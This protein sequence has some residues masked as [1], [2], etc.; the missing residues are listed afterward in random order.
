MTTATA[1]TILPDGAR[2]PSASPYPLL[3][4]NP[5]PGD[6]F[7]PATDALGELSD[8]LIPV[9]DKVFGGERLSM[10][11]GRLLFATK[12]LTGV[13]A[14]ANWLTE[15]RNG[16]RTTFTFNRHLN[17][18]NVCAY[19]CMFCAFR[20]SGDEDDA[21]TMDMDFVT[22]RIRNEFTDGM[23]EV[24]VVG[25]IHP[26][27]PYSYYL[28][29]LRTIKKTR[30]H[31]HIKGF[32]MIELNEIAKQAG[33]PLDVVVRELKEAGLDSCPGGGAEVLSPRVHKKLYNGKL[34]PNEWLDAVRV[35]HA[36]GLKSNATMLFGHIESLEER[37]EHLDQIRRLQDETQ[38]FMQFIPLVFHPDNTPL[39]RL[40][41][42][43][44]VDALR[45]IAISRLML[46]NIPHIKAYWIMVGLRIAQIALHYGADDI[47]GTVVEEH[48]THDAG[49]TTPQ[50]LTTGRLTAL[51]SETGR[52][53]V[54]RDTL[55][56]DMLAV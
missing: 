33:K 27:L 11:D 52:Q 6:E 14:L 49:A 34:P 24:H 26:E 45:T 36:A 23:K 41:K 50:G 10:D 9:R 47:D 3:P 4:S 53:P 44:G 13:G 20:R 18:T 56:E 2:V 22:N 12:D 51:I 37:L 30:P 35:V 28:D 8:E 7:E 1:N 38:G 19:K 29:L 32:T 46:D 15:T 55:Y 39:E 31:L 54:L 21:I 40:G 5:G 17:Y 25:G 48:I 43:T 16:N 42:T